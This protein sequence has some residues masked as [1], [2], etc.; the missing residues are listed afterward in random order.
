VIPLCYSDDTRNQRVAW[1]VDGADLD[2]TKPTYPIINLDAGAAVSNLWLRVWP[3]AEGESDAGALNACGTVGNMIVGYTAAGSVL[4]V[5]PS[6]QRATTTV[7]DSGQS[8]DVDTT[9]LLLPPESVPAVEDD[10]FQPLSMEWPV[11][12]GGGPGYIIYAE[13]AS[14][15]ALD[16]TLTLVERR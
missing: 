13:G 15:S 5:D 16:I 6:V 1:Y 14:G 7:T 4:R 2:L 3:L 9:H 8:F 12:Y 11:M 10:P